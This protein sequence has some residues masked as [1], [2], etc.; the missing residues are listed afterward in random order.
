MPGL[1][2]DTRMV[3]RGPMFDGRTNA[4]LHRYRDEISLRIAE[5][6]EKLIRQRLH[7]VLQHPTG[8]YESRISVDR[9][10]S[11]YRVSDGNVIYGPWL[12][13]TGS[14]NSPVT[15]FP[16]YATFRRTKPLVDK[17]AREIAVRLLARY[18]AMGLI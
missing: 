9:A 16:G 6:G 12:E 17:R 3:R 13:G 15:R 4:A 18:K 10:G 8:Y 7:V 2:L 11:G 5:E 14:R 1:D